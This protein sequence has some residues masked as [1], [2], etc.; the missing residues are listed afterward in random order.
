MPS[1]EPDHDGGQ[2]GTAQELGDQPSPQDNGVPRAD[3]LSQI[4]PIFVDQQQGVEPACAPTRN[5][6]ERSRA[7]S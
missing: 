2:E 3:A 6:M 1:S 4:D 5:A 7:S